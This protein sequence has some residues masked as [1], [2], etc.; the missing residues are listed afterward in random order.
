MIQ[1]GV[2]PDTLPVVV[3]TLQ[4]VA[5]SIAQVVGTDVGTQVTAV[6][7]LGIGLVL[8]FAV[9]LGKKL[10]AA[11]ATAPDPVKAFAVVAFGQLVTFIAAKTG[12]VLT[13]DL[14]TLQTTLSGLVISLA[15]MGFH[16]L[17]R[18]LFPKK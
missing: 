11:F 17:S 15:S 12:I 5:D 3:D 6:V 10:S 8:K 7:S 9:D 1:I 13:G 18:V 4:Q 16:S 2:T 14:T